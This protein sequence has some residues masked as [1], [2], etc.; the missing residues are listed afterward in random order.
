MCIRDS[1]ISTRDGLRFTVHTPWG[2]RPV[3]LQLTG[4][5][6]VHNSLAALTVALAEGVDIDVALAA[7][8]GVPG[9]RGR[10][11]RIEA[12]QPFTVLV[13]YAHT[14]GSF[15]K[16]MSIVRPLTPGPVS[17]THLAYHPFYA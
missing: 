1:I 4:D 7:L 14:P 9:V 5:F 11:Q 17:Y 10:M 2:I 13:D 16:L 15:E 12:G 3:A 6:N 8:A